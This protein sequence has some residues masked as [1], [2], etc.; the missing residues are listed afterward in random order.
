MSL[1]TVIPCCAADAPMAESL[2]DWML[3]LNSRKKLSCALVI[4]SGNTHEEMRMKLFLAAESAFDNFEIVVAPEIASTVKSEQVTQM[5]NFAAAGIAKNF[6]LPWLWLE[7]DSVPLKRSWLQELDDAYH[8]QPKRHFGP[9]FQSV[10]KRVFMSR[11]AVFSPDLVRAELPQ[12]Q[13]NNQDTITPAS[14][15]TKLIQ[16]IFYKHPQDLEKVRPE[17][18]LLHCDKS[19]MLIQHLRSKL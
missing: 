18:C 10:D 3:E 13:L 14:S 7:P 4:C 2:M 5:F 17:A 12:F 16:Q 19:G 6:R 11:T 1:L 8:S 15:K 9:H